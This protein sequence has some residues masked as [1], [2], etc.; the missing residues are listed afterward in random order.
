MANAVYVKKA[1]KDYP[2]AEIK[3]G[4]GYWKWSFRFGGVH[5]SKTKP[6]RSQL[7]QSSFLSTLY[8]IEDTIDD[9]FAGLGEQEE[10]ESALDDLIGDIES[11]RDEA[12]GSLDNMPEQ[13]H[14]GDTG[15]MLQDR[16]EGLESWISDLSSVDAIVDDELTKEEKADRIQEIIDEIT[17]TSSGL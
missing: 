1:R 13:L 12:E 6:S 7:T 11:L 8:D 16:I 15:Q 4:E 10:I 9:R 5:K 14:D 3:K 2:E 17:A